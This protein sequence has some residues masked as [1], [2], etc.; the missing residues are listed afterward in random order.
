MHSNFAR[1]LDIRSSVPAMTPRA[2]RL[3]PVRVS[4]DRSQ[5]LARQEDAVADENR[6]WMGAEGRDGPRA[7][8]PGLAEDIEEMW[9]QLVRERDEARAR[10]AAL[11]RQLARKAPL[12]RQHAVPSI[13]LERFEVDPA[14]IEIIPAET[15]RRYR[16]LPLCVSRVFTVAMADPS[17]Q[18][19]VEE[20]EAL[21]GFL[22]QPVAAPES[23]L[24]DALD[25]YYGPPGS[26]GATARRAARS[27][28]RLVWP[29][30]RS[31]G[32][33]AGGSPA[34]GRPAA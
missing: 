34:G 14:F 9:R 32:E 31:S 15:A 16:V 2:R 11:E 24:A 1:T 19:A 5:R 20:I 7:S 6:T 33:D 8:I 18:L 30:R 26:S 10:V 4:C 23:A 13:D 25:H 22:V 17:D 29:R 21:T 3:L 27:R 12:S 28:L